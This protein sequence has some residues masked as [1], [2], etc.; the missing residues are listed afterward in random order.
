MNDITELREYE[1]GDNTR[2]QTETCKVIFNKAWSQSSLKP[3]K[4]MKNTIKKVKILYKMLIKIIYTVFFFSSMSKH[5]N[6]ANSTEFVSCSNTTGNFDTSSSF[7][8]SDDFFEIDKTSTTKKEGEK[9]TKKKKTT[10]TAMKAKNNT[11]RQDKRKRD[12]SKNSISSTPSKSP[13]AKKLNLDSTMATPK[14]TQVVK[15]R[16]TF[17]NIS[18]KEHPKEKLNEDLSERIIDYVSDMRSIYEVEGRSAMDL[19]K[20]DDTD[21]TDDGLIVIYCGDPFTAKWVKELSFKIPDCPKLIVSIDDDEEERLGRCTILVRR[22]KKPYKIK[23]FQ[24]QLCNGNPGLVIK[25]LV[26]RER[27]YLPDDPK[28]MVLGFS[29]DFDAEEWF[30]SVQ[31]LVRFDLKKTRVF[32]PGYNNDRNDAKRIKKD[33]I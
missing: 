27:K 3:K 13:V 8:F 10:N 5:S 18:H 7:S 9:Q 12:I 4:Y 25:K 26:L 29:V 23:D 21:F 32:Y 28:H 14:T 19:V 2:R 22:R 31:G 11:P 6:K 15:A 30:K 16:R 20:I 17:V 24:S 33:E 1:T